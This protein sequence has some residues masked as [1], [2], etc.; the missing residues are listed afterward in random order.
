MAAETEAEMLRRI[1]ESNRERKIN[2]DNRMTNQ[3]LIGVMSAVAPQRSW[4]HSVEPSI[5]FYNKDTVSHIKL[6]RVLWVDDQWEFEF[7]NSEES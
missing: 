6:A 5:I 7:I 3:Y 1:L 2:P 4:H